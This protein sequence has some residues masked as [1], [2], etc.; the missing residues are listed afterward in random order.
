MAER[1]S[2]KPLVEVRV[3]DS[4]PV[5]IENVKKIMY[6]ISVRDWCQWPACLPS[7]QRVGVRVPY[8]A[9]KYPEVV[10]FGRTLD[11]GSRGRRFKPCLP[12]HV[13]ITNCLQN[14][15]KDVYFNDDL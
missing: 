14:K 1:W 11:L 15:N 4:L 3:L 8:L 7:K 13:Q 12:D 2:P 10:Q 5:K 9:P 6:I